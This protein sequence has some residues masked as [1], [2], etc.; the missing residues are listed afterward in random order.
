ME[1]DESKD[2][3]KW[4]SDYKSRGWN[5]VGTTLLAVTSWFAQ[6]FFIYVRPKVC[7]KDVILLFLTGAVGSLMPALHGYGALVGLSLAGCYI[8]WKISNWQPF[9]DVMMDHMSKKMQMKLVIKLTD[10]C[11]KH[12]KNPENEQELIKELNNEQSLFHHMFKAT[13]TDFVKLHLDYQDAGCSLCNLCQNAT[14]AK[15]NYALI[16]LFTLVVS[17]LMLAPGVQDWLTKVPFCEESTTTMGQ[18]AH[19]VPGSDH[20]KIRCADAIGYLAVYRV[21]FVVTL[22]FLLMGLIMIGVKSSRDSRLGLQNGFWGVKY[23]LIVGGI[24]GAFFIPHGGFGQT[25]MYFGLLGGLA[26][27]L[28]QLVLIIDF[29]HT[30]AESWQ[31]NYHETSNQNWFYALLTCTFGFFILVV[32]MIAFCFSYYTGLQAGDCKLH[33]FFISFNMILC[34]ILSGVSVLPMVQEHQPHSGLLQASFVSLYIMYLTWSAMTNQ[35]IG[36]DVFEN[37]DI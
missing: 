36:S 32:V 11:V 7:Q 14:M 2:T 24:I 26:F 1:T 35:P 29:A 6:E 37:R 34:L 13:I 4:R 3:T 8:V 22:F 9:Q 5:R 30:W 20:I 18:L 33:E 15:L 23:I 28:I 10:V 21:C 31:E 17:C 25:W 19:F 12:A 16:L 27:I